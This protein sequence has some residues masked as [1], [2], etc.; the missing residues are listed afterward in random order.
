M[1]GGKKPLLI[2]F[3][4]NIMLIPEKV[5]VLASSA[6]CSQR[7]LLSLCPPHLDKNWLAYSSRTSQSSS[8]AYSQRQFR[9]TQ[10]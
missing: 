7:W 10:F 9:E 5:S 8:S 4:T 6:F 2:L 3:K 1:E